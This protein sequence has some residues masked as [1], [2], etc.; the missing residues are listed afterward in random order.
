MLIR[1]LILVATLV[2]T[3]GAWAKSCEEIFTDPPSGGHGNNALNLPAGIFNNVKDLNCGNRGCSPVSSSFLPGDYG[4]DH[5]DF[6]NG[7]RITT[8][9]ATTRL[10]FKS[11]SLTNSSLNINGDAADLI[12]YVDG[13]LSVA[14]QNTINGIVYVK[15]NVSITG[16][17]TIDGALAAGGS[18]NISGNGDVDFDDDIFEDADFGGLCTNSSQADFHL[19]FGKVSTTSGDGYV[20]FSSPFKADVTPIVFVMPTI[21]QI[22]TNQD[23]PSS[24]QISAISATGFNFTQIDPPNSSRLGN[25][26]PDIHW[27]AIAPGKHTLSDGT[28]LFAGKVT[29]NKAINL[30]NFSW[31]EVDADP[32]LSVILNQ[33]QTNNTNCWLTSVAERTS[34]GFQLALDTSEVISNSR[35][36]P[37]NISGIKH[38]TIGFLAIEPGNGQVILNGKAVQY[39]FGSA[40]NYSS[41]SSSLEQQ[42]G[43]LTSLQNF[44]QAPVLVA[45]KNSRN[46]LEGG[47]LRRCQLDA[48]TVSMVIDEDVY[49]DSERSHGIETYGYIAL[50]P[51]EKSLECFSDD[52]N[53][54][55]IGENWVLKV[56]DSS[57]PPSI[58]SGRLRVTAALGNQSAAI[59]YNRL[60]PAAGNLVE[61]EF[62][63]FAYSSSTGTGGDGMAVVLSD[64]TVTPQPGSFGG[65]L[66]Y[67]QR[68]GTTASKGFAGGWLGVGLDE[69]GNFANNNEGK[70]GGTNGLRSQSVSLRGAEATNYPFLGVSQSPLNPKIDSRPSNIASPGYRYRISIDSRLANSATVSVARRTSVGG[71]FTTLIAPINVYAANGSVPADF[72]LSLTGSTGGANNNHEIDNFQVCALESRPIG[73]Q[74]HHFQFEYSGSPLACAPLQVTVKACKNANCSQL[75]SGNVIANLTPVNGTGLN[76]LDENKNTI[77]NQVTIVN[78]ARTLFLRQFNQT[79]IILGVSSSS[80]SSAAFA[81]TLCSNGSSLSAANCTVSFAEAGFIIDDVETYANKPVSA[82]IMAVR[83]SS[84]ALECQP[85]FA[86]QTKSLSLWSSYLDPN[87]ALTGESLKVD[88]TVIGKNQAGATPKSLSFDA[89]GKARVSVLYADAGKVAL[90]ARYVGQ[91]AGSDSGLIMASTNGN[92]I[93]VPAGLCIVPEASYNAGSNGVFKRAGDS[94]SVTLSARAWLQNGDSNFCD[95]PIT[96][97]FTMANL[98]LKSQR[99]TPAAGVDAVVTPSV[100]TQTLG[101]EFKLNQSLNEVGIYKLIASQPKASSGVPLETHKYLG[102]NLPIADGISADVGRFVPA[103]FRISGQSLLPGCSAGDFSYMAQPM[104]LGLTLTA[105]N[106]QNQRTYN[107]LGSLAKASAAAVAENNNDGISLSPRLSALPA[108][109]WAEGQSALPVTTELSFARPLAPAIDGPFDT[110]VIGIM[111][112]DNDGGHGIVADPDMGVNSMG[113]CSAASG[114]CDALQLLTTKVRAG[115]VVMDNTYG[116]ETAELTMPSRAEYWDGALWQTNNLDVCTN[117]NA[118]LTSSV[119]N[120]SLGYVFDPDLTAAQS[121]TRTRNSA[122][123]QG[124]FSLMWQQL[125]GYRGQITA[126][127]IVPTWLQWYWSWDGNS[128]TVLANPRASAFFGSYRGNDKVIYWRERSE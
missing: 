116:P 23:F 126:P 122:I 74:V 68:S 41:G 65:A 90:N 70:N 121:V 25:V 45:G 61:I 58:N 42:C 97:S 124:Q 63:H 76:W 69:Y 4:F 17:A 56:L 98:A 80:P 12:I 108:L 55:D 110:L 26:M 44:N 101:G 109:V 13:D 9:G 10:Y 15:G 20:S 112:N 87:P 94:Y 105:E 28:R 64:A 60:F 83:R 78:G 113:D 71:A 117:F 33:K 84:G 30:T 8:N 102:S 19:Q 22:G 6:N 127:L 27:I 123:N 99:V 128:P 92:M 85:T 32:S 114:G 49:R 100:Y 51:V 11:L 57:T 52:F 62:D 82:A 111:V 119:D 16:K 35:C 3:H 37:D 53:R 88:G 5:G 59:S 95:N 34:D 125:G 21:S 118:S 115:R 50:Q 29:T 48:K 46:S 104:T 67:A 89:E 7:S 96:P 1:S 40:Q 14:G 36:Q 107:Y 2:V 93:N 103:K 86:N 72:L 106:V 79:P 54:T 91:S 24:T 75:F 81:T 73:E 77:G 18:L 47:W 120:P 38:E 31:S 66:G 43:Y 39:Q